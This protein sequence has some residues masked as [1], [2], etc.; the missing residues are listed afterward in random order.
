MSSTLSNRTD[1][2]VAAERRGCRPAAWRRCR[3]GRR[4]GY[5]RPAWVPTRRRGNSRAG[6]MPLPG[7]PAGQVAPSL[8]FGLELPRRAGPDGASPRPARLDPFTLASRGRSFLAAAGRATSTASL[9]GRTRRWSLPQLAPNPLEPAE[10][11]GTGTPSV[12]AAARAGPTD[13]CALGQQ[14]A[15]WRAHR[16]VVPRD[17]KT[18]ARRGGPRRRKRRSPRY[19]NSAERPGFPTE[20]RRGPTLGRPSSARPAHARPGS[21]TADT[22]SSRAGCRPP[23]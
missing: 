22:R 19:P 18:S 16:S 17:L 3:R 23:R 21:G 2:P 9:V 12:A 8:P 10:S 20:R 6:G 5:R 15:S 14:G 13:A 7:P 11:S 1:R 4:A